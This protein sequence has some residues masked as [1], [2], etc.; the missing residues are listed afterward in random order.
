M[1][2]L[3]CTWDQGDFVI[4]LDDGSVFPMHSLCRTRED[5]ARAKAPAMLP[6]LTK[7]TVPAGS[8]LFAG[9]HEERDHHYKMNLKNAMSGVDD[10]DAFLRRREEAEDKVLSSLKDCF[11]EEVEI[12]N[13]R[14]ALKN[15]KW[16]LTNTASGYMAL[17]VGVDAADHMLFPVA[18]LQRLFDEFNHGAR[19]GPQESFCVTNYL[20]NRSNRRRCTIPARLAKGVAAADHLLIPRTSV[21]LLMKK[22]NQRRQNRWGVFVQE[23]PRPE[24]TKR[25]AGIHYECRDDVGQ[26]LRGQGGSL[27]LQCFGDGGYAAAAAS[28]DPKDPTRVAIPSWQLGLPGGHVQTADYC[29]CDNELTRTQCRLE[30]AERIGD[31]NRRLALE[32]ETLNARLRGE[33]LRA[34]ARAKRDQKDILA[35]CARA[36]L[37]EDQLR[38]HTTTRRS[39]G[40]GGGGRGGEGRKASNLS[41][42]LKR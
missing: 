15:V 24:S 32:Y 7:F 30:E 17:T 21:G 2:S 11:D 16:A 12:E 41:S 13:F 39:Y 33:L 23:L 14:V 5:M 9:T 18:E 19:S 4:K 22:I 27:R 8:D 25:G 1:A 40:R 3:H 28:L 29:N 26:E 10:K 31:E 42:T 35:Q 37:L 6:W 20:F 36:E 34:D 38:E